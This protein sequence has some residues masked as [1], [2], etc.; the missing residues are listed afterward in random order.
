MAA[1]LRRLYDHLG[2]GAKRVAKPIYR[3]PI[4]AIAS[5]KRRRLGR[6]RYIAVTGSS[7]KTTTKDLI[8]DLLRGEYETSKSDDTNNQIFAV[9][10]ALLGMRS[11]TQFLVQEIGASITG[12]MDYSLNLLK[13]DIGVV[14]TVGVEHFKEFR[15]RAAVAAEKA[16]LVACLPQTGVAILN[17]D[18]EFVRNLASKTQAQIFTF[19]FS[20]SSDLRVLHASSV[21]PEC[22]SME[23]Q[24]RGQ[25]YECR[26]QFYGEH[27]VHCV[28]AALATAIT[29]G[30][31]IES[32]IDRISRC[33]PTLARM[34]PF[35]TASGIQFIRDD[36][37]APYWSIERP[38]DF[39]RQAKA[40]RK[41]IVFGTISDIAGTTA[42]KYRSVAESA[43]Q[44]ADIVYFF[45][46]NSGKALRARDIPDGKDLRAFKS[47][48]ELAEHLTDFLEKDDL[49]LLKSS[50]GDHL[51][52]LA[53]MFERNLSC[54]RQRCQRENMCDVCALVSA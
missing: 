26:T 9:A 34:S 8:H 17:S 54:W 50:G 37:K 18:D 40:K 32:A 48:R 51:A 1:A 47:F 31:S 6:A 13:P 35:E 41:I 21:W 24:Y 29:V 22:L 38:I 28:L 23:I 5:H 12:E 33:T 49:V 42:T 15:T 7:G 46:S 39:M 2:R 20:E 53:I 30:V 25:R 36:W 43:L 3:R 11:D 45:G 14:T 10:R 44:A 19:G 52:R 27:L 16:K 4:I